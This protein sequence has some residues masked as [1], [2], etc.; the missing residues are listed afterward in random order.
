MDLSKWTLTQSRDESFNLRTVA[1]LLP[2]FATA[3]NYTIAYSEDCSIKCAMASESMNL[4]R[5]ESAYLNFWFYASAGMGSNEGVS[6]EISTN[7]GNSWTEIAEWDGGD[8]YDD[9]YW[10][11]V[12]NFDLGDHLAHSDVKLKLVATTS[13]E[14]EIVQIGNYEVRGDPLSDTIP[15]IITVPD[16]VVGEAT[17]ILT[18]VDIGAATATD[19]VDPSPAITNDAPAGGFSLGVTTITW[20]ATDD[21]NNS[22]AAMQTV[23]IRDTTP[24][25]ITVPADASFDATGTLTAL[26][27]DDYGTATAT[28]LVD[29]HPSITNNAPTSFP[30]G[31][32]TVTWTATDSSNNSASATQTITLNLGAIQDAVR[33]EI[34]APPDITAEAAG[35][36]TAV[37]I[38]QAVATDN[39]DPS[40]AVTNDAPASF[41]LG[42]TIVTWTATDDS[43]N[44]AADTQSV[45]IRDTTPPTISAHGDVTRL[46]EPGTA[47]VVTFDAPAA[48][49]T[50]DPD[51]EVSC[52]PESG[53]VFALG[54]TTVICTATDDSGNTAS[55]SFGV[56]VDVSLS[57]STDTYPPVIVPSDDYVVE[58]TGTLTDVNIGTAF[59]F[60]DA[61]RFLAHHNAQ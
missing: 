59:A 22:A 34:A 47:H 60:D 11:Y 41:P 26:A 5:Y 6:L 39:V 16:D 56:T 49:D 29:P 48:A 52:T 31:T 57:D 53:S 19:N 25:V 61:D 55:T 14:G 54:T 4:S 37:D 43:G 58:A 35:S 24:P 27:R 28:D 8:Y 40:P 15:P 10:H 1:G 7:G 21:A 13:S 36:L 2:P 44:T 45:T 50:V 42:T 32:T 17:G 46:F 33:P 3:L 38:G 51:I 18:K 30:I 20:T 9:G 12:T 23:T